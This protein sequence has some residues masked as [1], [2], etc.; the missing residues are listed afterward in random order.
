MHIKSISIITLVILISHITIAYGQTTNNINELL[1]KGIEEKKIKHYQQAL[2][3]FDRS[4]EIDPN[5]VSALTNKGS[6]LSLEGNNTGALQYF[7][8]SLEIDPNNVSALTNKV[9][10][11]TFLG[12]Y[13]EAIQ[14]TDK[15]LQ[16]DPKNVD[17]LSFK[18]AI[19]GLLG[20]YNDSLNYADIALK[21]DPNNVSALTNKGTALLK[22]GNETKAIQ[23]F[24]RALEIDPAYVNA[25]NNRG[26]AF[27]KLGNL[28]AALSDFNK[29]IEINPNNMIITANNKVTL[30]DRLQTK[31][32]ENSRFSHSILQVAVFNSKG[33]LTGYVETRSISFTDYVTT[34]KI[35]DLQPKKTIITIDGEK[36]EQTEMIEKGIV[37]KDGTFASKFKVG[38]TDGPITVIPF[39]ADS[40]GLVVNEGD[41]LIMDWKIVRPT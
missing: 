27:A 39:I 36:F 5:N 22:L 35:I 14:Y 24:N 29:V 26:A 11:L 20:K 25:L 38:V 34:D 41:I 18:S 23:Y 15:T 9:V 28:T 4:L 2:Q 13:S 3:Y 40:P 16:I 31:P 33:L 12:N 8:R 30:Y 32:I 17:A 37:P 19:F 7:D 21:I 1:E 6:I 10:A